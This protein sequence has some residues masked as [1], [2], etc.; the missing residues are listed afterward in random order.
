MNGEL[1]TDE[2][3]QFRD[4]WTSRI[5]AGPPVVEPVHNVPLS[6]FSVRLDLW[7]SRGV[8]ESWYDGAQAL[9]TAILVLPTAE[10]QGYLMS[11]AE[12]VPVAGQGGT[13]I[14]AKWLG[15]AKADLLEIMRLPR[16]WDSYGAEPITAD[17][18]RRAG[19]LLEWMAVLAIPGPSILPTV[20]GG[21]Q[22]EWHIRGLNAEV[23]IT[24]G[25]A[26][27]IVYFQDLRAGEEWERDLGNSL[28]ELRTLRSR[29]LVE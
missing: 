4:S 16:Y 10:M 21:I 14:F 24:D 13:S 19:E 15:R 27:V 9:A 8:S 3:T 6:P 1:L 26:R 5:L 17:A 29:L 2:K 11:E 7:S 25:G 12:A 20:A 18:A 28:D 23:E 22:L